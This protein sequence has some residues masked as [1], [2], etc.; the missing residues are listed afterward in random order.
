MDVLWLLLTTLLI[1]AGRTTQECLH[2]QGRILMTLERQEKIIGAAC[3]CDEAEKLAVRVDVWTEEPCHE[4]QDE[5]VVM[6]PEMD[7]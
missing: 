5:K 3:D 4:M 1:A 6:M 2:L 7:L